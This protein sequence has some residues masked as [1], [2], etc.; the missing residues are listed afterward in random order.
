MF[1]VEM[2]EA[3]SRTWEHHAGEAAERAGRA[4][5]VGR[6][7]ESGALH[8]LHAV[9]ALAPRAQAL[10][11]LHRAAQSGGRGGVKKCAVSKGGCGR[12]L[13]RTTFERLVGVRWLLVHQVPQRYGS[14]SPRKF[15]CLPEEKSSLQF[16]TCLFWKSAL[17]SFLKI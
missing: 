7:L 12:S 10:Q 5:V 13:R 8:L 11:G 16:P 4:V 1:P 14:V 17:K 6:R 3:C 2:N 15:S 9:H